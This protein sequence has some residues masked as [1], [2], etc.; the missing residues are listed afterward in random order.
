M[1]VMQRFD[2]HESNDFQHFEAV[3]GTVGVVPTGLIS[4]RQPRNARYTLVRIHPNYVYK[5][6][7]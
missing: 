1:S 4:A 6:V 7:G 2:I 3:V 5:M